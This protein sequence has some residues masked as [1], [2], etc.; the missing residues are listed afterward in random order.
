MNIVVKNY[1]D[2]LLS[3]AVS[4]LSISTKQRIVS[5]NLGKNNTK[6]HMK[7]YAEIEKRIG[8]TKKCTFGHIRGSKTGVKHEGSEDVPIR[9]FE[10]MAVFMNQNQE[11]VIKKGDGLQGFCRDCSK[12]RR[13]S[14]I[15]SEKT[16][17]KDKTR[18]EIEDMYKE[19][20]KILTKQCSRCHAKK[21][22]N[23]FALS[24]TMECGFHN[25]C[26]ICSYEY[27]SSISDRWIIYM[28]DGHYKCTKTEKNQHDDH[29]FPSSIIT[30]K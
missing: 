12:R 18:S 28:P 20:Y 9:E 17:K 21:D 1:V 10:L 2:I 26:Q 30:V 15:T 8:K 25:I 11:V 6:Y 27:S 16:Q 22:L 4:L 24:I 13:K 29:I 23:F 3:N 7:M 5:K 19:K 14:R